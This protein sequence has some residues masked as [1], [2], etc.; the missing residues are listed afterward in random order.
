MIGL[1]RSF[2]REGVHEFE[3]GGGTGSHRD[4]DGAVELDNRRGHEAGE[5]LIQLH[6]GRPVS[7]GRSSGTCV[8]AA[9]GGLN[10]VRAG[11][12]SHFLGAIERGEAAAD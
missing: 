4:C 2:R 10:D 12:G 8:T 7:F 1:E 9:I 11:C 6:D 5:L 3:A